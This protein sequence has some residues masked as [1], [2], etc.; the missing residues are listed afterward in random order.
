M[1]KRQAKKDASQDPEVRRK[2][3]QKKTKDFKETGN[4]RVLIP[5][6]G[7]M[8]KMLLKGAQTQRDL[9]GA[10]FDTFS[11]PAKHDVAISMSE[12]TTIYAAEVKRDG[13]GHKHG[14]PHIWAAGGLLKAL[15]GRGD[16]VGASTAEK[17]EEIW[18]EVDKMTN[19]AKGETFMFCRL[20]QF[21][22]YLPTLTRFEFV[23]KFALSA[24]A[25]CKQICFLS[26]PSL[27]V[28]PCSLSSDV[29]RI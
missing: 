7:T 27:C 22:L 15:K 20:A 29:R 17:I 23:Y 8:M 13:K 28:E 14:P 2:E 18:E 4:A 12:Q 3:K 10:V 1:Y 19:E 9:A 5:L 26:L 16:K 6:L 21:C 25:Q 24:P 11:G